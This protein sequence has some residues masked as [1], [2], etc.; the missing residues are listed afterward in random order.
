MHPKAMQED[1]KLS[2]EEIFV[3]NNRT[4]KRRRKGGYY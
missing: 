2:L 4:L 1:N 3:I